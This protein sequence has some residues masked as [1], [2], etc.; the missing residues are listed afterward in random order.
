MLPHS[1]YAE[2]ELNEQEYAVFERFEER[3]IRKNR[4]FL[5]LEGV[6]YIFDIYLGSSMGR[7]HRPRRFRGGRSRQHLPGPAAR[8]PR[9]FE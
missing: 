4:Y 1:A 2:L 3:E 9:D 6:R 7:K 8:S 5:E